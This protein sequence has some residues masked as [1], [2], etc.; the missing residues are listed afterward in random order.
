MS[1][2][3]LLAACQPGGNYLD[4]ELTC[5]AN[6]YAWWNDIAMYADMGKANK[7][8]PNV[9]EWDIEYEPAYVKGIKGKYNGLTGDLE[10][11]IK[12]S[13]DYFLVSEETVDSFENYGTIFRNG[14]LDTRAMVLVT[15]KLGNTELRVRR[16]ERRGCVGSTRYRWVTEDGDLPRSPQYTQNYELVSDDKVTWDAS[17]EW[18]DGSTLYEVG[19]W[20]SQHVHERVASYA[21]DGYSSESVTRTKANGSSKMVFTD[22]STSYVFEGSIE[23]K[24]SGDFTER[25]TVTKVSDGS[26]YAT[27]ET[28]RLYDRSGTGTW[29]DSDKTCTLT[30]EVEGACS[31]T[32]D[33]GGSVSC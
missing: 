6:P 2:L 28:Q 17:S 1:I 24:K 20:S 32:C 30:Y 11:A 8:K 5:A 26:L 23:T 15:D 14:N 10:Y 9:Q 7:N 16:D 27:V 21:L 31:S 25:Y 19:S 29:V 13:G 22:T 12:Y 3:L 18:A 33:N 4:D